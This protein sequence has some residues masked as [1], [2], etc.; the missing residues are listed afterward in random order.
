VQWFCNSEEYA[1]LFGFHDIMISLC[2]LNSRK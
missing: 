1:A 2:G